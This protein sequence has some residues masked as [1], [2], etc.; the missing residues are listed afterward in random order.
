MYLHHVAK[1]V[2]WKPCISYTVLVMFI[3]M[4]MM[5]EHLEAVGVVLKY[6]C[7]LCNG[8]TVVVENDKIIEYG[9]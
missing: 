9:A 1:M 3:F 7:E 6:L 8:Y 2:L 5:I 4:L